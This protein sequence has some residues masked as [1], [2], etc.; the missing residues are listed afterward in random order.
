MTTDAL[1]SKI[2]IPLATGMSAG[3][4]GTAANAATTAATT[5]GTSAATGG[6][7]A[8]I[9]ATV[10]TA[11]SALVGGGM[12][13]FGMTAAS[14]GAIATGMSAMP[15]MAAIGAVAAPLLAVVAVFSFF[16]KKTKELDSGLN[17]TVKNMDT[18]VE[19]FS[20][21][22][23]SKFWGLSKTTS[24]TTGAAPDAVANPIIAA[25]SE[26]QNQVVKAAD[27]LGIASDAFEGFSYDFKLSLKGL[28]EEQAMVKINEELLKMGDSFASMTGLFSTMNELLAVTQERM[29]LETKLLNMQGNVVELR[30]QELDAVHILNKGLAARIQLLEAEADMSSALAAFASGISQQ[31][32]LIK[33]AVDALISPLIEAI[34]RVKT[35]AEAS[36]RIF[37]EAADK[38]RVEAKTIVDLLRGALDA[39]AIKSEGLDLM[40]YKQAQRQLSDFA[41]GA[42]FDKESL[43]KATE[44]VSIDSQKFFG[45]FADYARDFS[46]TQVSLRELES[47][48]SE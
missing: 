27:A 19:S 44:G 36:Y 45:S 33:S 20:K 10:G 22:Q 37:S 47:I 25:V 11:G 9:G 32:G 41:G 24:T 46:R 29:D 7:M 26:I 15:A 3:F 12:S 39:R 43:S 21:V 5:A 34:N 2:L 1:K 14:G 31:Q 38:T 17:V 35:E 8:G 30:K 42:S 23:T 13:A 18:F 28:T 48:A 40:R 6:M 16:K 4:A